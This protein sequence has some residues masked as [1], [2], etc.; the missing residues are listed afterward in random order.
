MLFDRPRRLSRDLNERSWSFAALHATQLFLLSFAVLIAAGTTGF[1]LLPGLY[2]GEGL[3]FVDALFTATSAVCVTGLIVVDT[4]TYFTPLGQAWIALLIQL[5]GLGILTFTTLVIGVLGRRAS[6]G[7]TEAAGGDAT[8]LPHLAPGQLVRYV[9]GATLVLETVGAVSLWWAWKGDF[10][11]AGAV[12]PAVFHA[13]SAFCNAGFSIFTDSLEG[14]AGRP[15]VVGVVSILVVLG[16]L[17]FIVLADLWTRWSRPDVRRFSTHSRLVL[18]STAAL[19]GGATV[20]Y[21]GFELPHTLREMGWIDRLTNAW[22]MAVTPRTAGFNTVDYDAVSNPALFLTVLLM[23]VGGSPG[24]TAGGIKTTTLT[25][26][27]LAFL[28]RLRGHEHVSVAGRSIP[29]ETVHRAAAL[30]VGGLVLLGVAVLVLTMVEQAGGAGVTDRVDFLRLVFEAH[31]AF[32]TVGLSMGV[33]DT[34]SSAGRV[35]VVVLMYLGRVGP[36][37]VASAMAVAVGRKTTQ[38]RYAQEDVVIG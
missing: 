9:V 2:T 11:A 15:S 16:G 28:Q 34:L 4:A 23:I 33:T 24:S 13:I 1:M 6:L 38:Y 26:L 17:G 37:A 27:G 21:L 31:S 30:T 18:I 32:G 29:S 25:L 8:A 20:L 14:F 12:G 5:G 7:A 22:F 19:L 10:G 35:V 3:G 36:L